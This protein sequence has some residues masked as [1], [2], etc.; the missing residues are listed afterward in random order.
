MNNAKKKNTEWGKQMYAR[1]MR[2]MSGE[3]IEDIQDMRP[4]PLLTLPIGRREGAIV[5][6]LLCGFPCWLNMEMQTSKF[7]PKHLP[8]ICTKK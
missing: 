8:N 4:D 2:D 3:P 7:D 1:T 5:I 6:T